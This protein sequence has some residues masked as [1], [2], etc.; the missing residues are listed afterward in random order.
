MKKITIKDVAKRAGVSVST[1]SQYLNKRYH[2]MS[3]ATKHRIDVAIKEL[4]YEPNFLARNLKSKSTKTIG[5]IVANI[6]HHFSTSITR[7]IE[8]YCDSNG[9]HLIIC[10]ADDDSEKEKK[11]IQNLISKQVDG[12]IIFPTFGNEQL[13]QQLLDK[14]YPIV[15]IDRYIKG[16][17]VPTFKLDNTSAI[18]KSYDYLMKFKLNRIYYISTSLDKN[19][20]PRIER[21]ETFKSIQEKTNDLNEHIIISEDVANLKEAIS[22]NMDLSVDRNGV[23]LANDF[24]LAEFLSFTTGQKLPL[25]EKFKLVS[26]DDIQLA[27]L[28]Q[29]PIST[30][31]QPIET[32]SENAL[33]CLLQQIKNEK[34]TYDLINEYEPVLIER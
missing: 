21:M 25:H 33:N 8:D 15:F 2:Y 27:Q 12:L 13:Y 26:I 3:D 30:I 18:Q 31:K 19:I 14:K 9:Y 10:N 22:R 11:Y 6:L 28:Y 23:I 5:I 32:I 16:L 4:D 29:P 34:H 20:T 1:V 17:N 7:S 24:A